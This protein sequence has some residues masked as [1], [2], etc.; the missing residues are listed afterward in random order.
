MNTNL[1][2]KST[3][4][5]DL[6][7]ERAQESGQESG[8]Y[9]DLVAASA[10]AAAP[11]AS[12]MK[13]VEPPTQSDLP[14]HP[15]SSQA[16]ALVSLFLASAMPVP[17][18]SSNELRQA[19][20]DA[21]VSLLKSTRPKD[22]IDHMGSSLL[23]ALNFAGL[24]CLARAANCGD[25]SAARDLNLRSGIKIGSVV[26]DLMKALDARHGRGRYGVNVGTVNV[27]SGGQ[28]IVGTVESSNKR[29]PASPDTEHAEEAAAGEAMLATKSTVTKSAA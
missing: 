5:S 20:A 27:E 24:N 19:F 12:T 6:G 18:N 1:P 13:D 10:P 9:G 7:A 4:D 25:S 2:L 8:K 23:I 3:S 14:E 11:P 26:S 16:E 22:A 28:A 15:I 29:A 17:A 21:T